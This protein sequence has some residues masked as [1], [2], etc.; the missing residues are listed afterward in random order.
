M[1]IYTHQG[2]QIKLHSELDLEAGRGTGPSPPSWAA[3]FASAGPPVSPGRNPLELQLYIFR[4]RRGIAYSTMH[5][6]K[7]DKAKQ[8]LTQLRRSPQKARDLE[9]LARL[10][11]R[12]RVKRGK[13]PTWES[14]ELAVYPLSIP[15]HGGRDIPIGTKNSILDQLEDDILTWEEMLELEDD[16]E[17]DEE[18][19]EESNGGDGNGTG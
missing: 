6:K 8:L 19:R 9:V 7:L 11:G 14:T 15:H 12:K 16:N 17:G 18:E 2:P 10:L 4:F 3:T 13:E 1:C 5:R